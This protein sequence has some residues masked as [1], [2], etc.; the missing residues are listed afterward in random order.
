[1]SQRS[2]RKVCAVCSKQ[3][4]VYAYPESTLTRSLRLPVKYAGKSHHHYKSQ[5]MDM[6]KTGIFLIG[7]S[8]ILWLFERTTQ[9]I[10]TAVGALYCG[11]SCLQPV[12]GIVDDASCGF[13]MDIYVILFLLLCM[14]PGFATLI[15]VRKKG[16]A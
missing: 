10:S 3:L 6:R 1:M 2:S 8:F 15:A 5:D 14:L 9:Y 16:H 11:K 13:N 7:C 4:G 12:N